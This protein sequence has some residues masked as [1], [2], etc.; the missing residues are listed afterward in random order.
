M[1]LRCREYIADFEL[2]LIIVPF[3]GS[4]TT[5]FPPRIIAPPRLYAIKNTELNEAHSKS[6]KHNPFPQKA[7]E[8][9][10]NLV[11]LLYFFCFNFFNC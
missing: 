3:S 5:N 8:R 7:L 4:D 6:S 10:K 1:P 2:T 11:L 9:A